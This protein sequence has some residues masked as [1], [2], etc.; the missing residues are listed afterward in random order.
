M[1]ETY[2][3]SELKHRFYMFHLCDNKWRVGRGTV[4]EMMSDIAEFLEHDLTMIVVFGLS[5]EK[6]GAIDD[7]LNAC[8]G[9][10]QVREAKE[11]LTLTSGQV[12]MIWSSIND[13][14]E[15]SLNIDVCDIDENGELNL[16]HAMTRSMLVL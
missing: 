15:S 9:N 3:D 11:I 6:Y 1:N 5:V 13:K 14:T 12:D 2:I 7:I 10:K 8:A 16:N 4:I